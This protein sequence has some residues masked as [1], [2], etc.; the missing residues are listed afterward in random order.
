MYCASSVYTIIAAVK[1]LTQQFTAI[2]TWNIR[3]AAVVCI[4]C[5]GTCMLVV[6]PTAYAVISTWNF[7]MKVYLKYG[8]NFIT[9]ASVVYI[10][11][12]S[13]FA[14]DYKFLYKRE[15]AKLLLY[16]WQMAPFVTVV[17]ITIFI[18]KYFPTTRKSRNISIFCTF[19][20]LTGQT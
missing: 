14:T 1:S 9:Y 3:I 18:K 12:I 19:Y 8:V 20:H 15:L 17:S 13:R 7:R 6:T 11:K 2:M 5:G 16:S 4:I 10:Y